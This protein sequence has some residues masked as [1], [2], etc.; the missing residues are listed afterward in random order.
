[1]PENDIFARLHNPRRVWAIG[2]IHGE[3]ERL[4]RLHV[5]VQQRFVPG[6]RLV[7]LGN[8]MGRGPHVRATVDEVLRLR[9][10][11]LALPDMHICDIVALR[12]SQEEMWQKVMQLQFAPNPREVLPWVVNQGVGATIEAYGGKIDE[13]IKAVRDGAVSITRWTNALRA[14]LRNATGHGELM[15]SLRRAALSDD[16][17]LLLVN[18]GIDITRPLDAQTDS[19]WWGGTDFAAITE[20]Y[21]EV[22]RIVRGFDRAKQGAVQ[23]QFTL[24][25]DAGCGRGGA[26]LGALLSPEGETIE[27]F[28]T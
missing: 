2:S 28:E 22:K 11:L 1:M 17:Q 19:F 10:K 23:N 18:A 8:I 14:T 26:L 5:V 3:V 6:D 12:G 24:S 7:Y 27:L 13:G 9:R 15:S 4:R 21:G 16:G 20:P 25:L